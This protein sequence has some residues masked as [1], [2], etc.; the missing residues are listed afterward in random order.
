[1]HGVK[2]EFYGDRSPQRLSDLTQG[3]WQA[4]RRAV[5]SAARGNAV[6]VK[7]YLVEYDASL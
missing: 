7:A 3:P 2:L 6:I 5:P 1:M 4:A